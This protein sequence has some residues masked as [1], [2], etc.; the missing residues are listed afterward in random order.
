MR[1]FARQKVAYDTRL[2]R[3]ARRAPVRSL[4]AHFLPQRVAAAAAPR[5]DVDYYVAAFIACCLFMRY[6]EACVVIFM[7]REARCVPILR[8]DAPRLLCLRH[9]A[10]AFDFE[11]CRQSR[12]IDAAIIDYA[13]L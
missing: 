4:S 1:V 8:Y 9:D 10:A 5:Y 13:A 7:L 11:T 12:A 6:G 2:C 3:F